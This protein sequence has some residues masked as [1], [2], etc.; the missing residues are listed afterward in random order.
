MAEEEKLKKELK[1]L[2]WL[3]IQENK[4]V[5]ANLSSNS[6]I[7]RFLTVNKSALE[8]RKDALT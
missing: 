5:R 8:L 3:D 4:S 1:P 7:K 6:N 2:Y